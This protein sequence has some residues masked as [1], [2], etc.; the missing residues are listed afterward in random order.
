MS[1]ATITV[2]VR[3]FAAVREALG[4]DFVVVALPAG[5]TLQDLRAALVARAPALSRVP[6]AYARNRDYAR[7][8]TVMADGDEVALIPPISGGDGAMDV[9][10][11]DLVHGPI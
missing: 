3:C 7:D 11:F 6:V 4:E 5:A 9:V 2:R 8:D 1:Q 10:R